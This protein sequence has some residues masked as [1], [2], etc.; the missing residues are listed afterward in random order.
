MAPL[1]QLLPAHLALQ[2]ALGGCLT[3]SV[4]LNDASYSLGTD[5]TLIRKDPSLLGQ[6]RKL[7]AVAQTGKSRVQIPR[8]QG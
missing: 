3:Q 2:P 5:D 1:Y 6:S 7:S 4:P 8:S